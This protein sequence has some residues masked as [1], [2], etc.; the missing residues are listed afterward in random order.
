MPPFLSDEAIRHYIAATPELDP[1]PAAIDRDGCLGIGRFAS[2][3]RDWTVAERAHVRRCG[4][5]QRRQRVAWSLECPAWADLVS[6]AALGA[7]WELAPALQQHID[8]D[9]DGRCAEQLSSLAI[10]SAVW[11]RGVPAR[12]RGGIS[13]AAE[14]LQGGGW[15]ESPAVA[16]LG[17]EHDSGDLG[18]THSSGAL[19]LVEIQDGE[20]VVIFEDL[21]EGHRP[22]RVLL[23][24]GDTQGTL[25]VPKFDKE[26]EAW[27]ARLG[28]PSG[29]GIDAILIEASGAGDDRPPDA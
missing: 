5:C 17:P 12:V 29:S 19:A 3:L 16:I 11:I 24:S 2:R 8:E 18:L 25:F 14:V 7:Q 15:A 6:F 9:C 4:N 27:I 28:P 1:P 21:P 23:L 26:A 22:P 20:L 10:Q 13:F